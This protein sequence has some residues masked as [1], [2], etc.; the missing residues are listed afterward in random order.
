MQHRYMELLLNSTSRGGSGMGGSAMGGYS[1]DGMDSKMADKTKFWGVVPTI[2]KMSKDPTNFY[3]GRTLWFSVI[4]LYFSVV[5][6]VQTTWT[7]VVKRFQCHGD[8]SALCLAQCYEDHFNRPVLGVWNVV[9][10]V[11]SS[12]F[13][14]MEFFVSQ[15]LHKETK[16]L[17]K[18][19]SDNSSNADQ[20][21]TE[22]ELFDL[23]HTKSLL[24]MYLVYFL[25]QGSIQAVFLVILIYYH[26]PLVQNP[27][28]CNAVTC[29]GLHRC[30]VK[31][32]QEMR[33]SIIL[34]ATLSVVIMTFCIMFFLYTINKYL[35]MV[36]HSKNNSDGHP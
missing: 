35:A 21:K 24:V 8:I 31:G 2:L 29:G 6:V 19:H 18:K 14:V 11:F 26:L 10:I 20:R 25:A 7:D 3:I 4:F 28:W 22:D 32:T 1:R 30:T 9:G 27:I 36:R 33:M 16:R 13:F 15:K 17:K 5:Y 34:L 23:S 12:I